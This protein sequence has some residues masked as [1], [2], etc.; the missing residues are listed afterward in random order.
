MMIFWP[1]ISGGGEKLYFCFWGCS[2][3]RRG[4]PFLEGKGTKVHLRAD[5]FRRP[6]AGRALQQVLLSDTVACAQ[7]IVI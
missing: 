1:N 6:R 5:V 3:S 4:V 2:C 7:R